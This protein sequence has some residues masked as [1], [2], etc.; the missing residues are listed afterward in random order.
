M[1][2]LLATLQTPIWWEQTPKPR[3]ES[4]ANCKASP[5]ASNNQLPR[6][7]AGGAVLAARP[8]P[9]CV[10]RRHRHQRKFLESSSLVSPLLLSRVSN[11]VRVACTIHVRLYR[12]LKKSLTA[13][14]CAS[15]NELWRFVLCFPH[16]P[17]VTIF[18]PRRNASLGIHVPQC[19][20]CLNIVRINRRQFEIM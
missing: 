7:Y 1:S 3:A 4:S 10:R 15:P 18:P 12:T 9:V 17:S 2:H 8:V 6:P 11:V 5:H 14:N 19:E 13:T 16:F 20:S